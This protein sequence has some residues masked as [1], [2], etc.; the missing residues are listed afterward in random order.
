MGIGIGTEGEEQGRVAK[1]RW[2]GTGQKRDGKVVWPRGAARVERF[3]KTDSNIKIET[4][5]LVS[6][7][8]SNSIVTNDCNLFIVVTFIVTNL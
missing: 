3:H 4:K 2:N 8:K 1:T 7:Q 6:L 5:R